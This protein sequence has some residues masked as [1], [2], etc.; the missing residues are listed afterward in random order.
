MASVEI[1]YD[2]AGGGI[3]L[4]VGEVHD[5]IGAVTLNGVTVDADGHHGPMLSGTLRL[6]GHQH[7]IGAVQDVLDDISADYAGNGLFLWAEARAR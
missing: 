6:A 1:A 2:S 3:E 4:L 5:R 7:D